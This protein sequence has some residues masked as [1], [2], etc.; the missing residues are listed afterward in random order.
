MGSCEAFA[1]IEGPA[2][3]KD[4]HEQACNKKWG[5][6][7]QGRQPLKSLKSQESKRSESQSKPS[8]NATSGKAQKRRRVN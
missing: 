5:R 2:N 7:E 3:F 1:S 8:G 4:A 6:M